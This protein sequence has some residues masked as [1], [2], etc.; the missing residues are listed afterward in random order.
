VAIERNDGGRHI[1]PALNNAAVEPQRVAQEEEME[2]KSQ[3][4][5]IEPYKNDRSGEAAWT[6]A[7][8]ALRELYPIR[9]G[10]CMGV[11]YDTKTDRYVAKF[12]LQRKPCEFKLTTEVACFVLQALSNDRPPTDYWLKM[13]PGGAIDD[14][15]LVT[16]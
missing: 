15:F 12:E 2:I 1:A 13:N 3:L 4:E 7:T 8:K 11:K 6:L 9:A 5:V 14:C 16:L 10:L